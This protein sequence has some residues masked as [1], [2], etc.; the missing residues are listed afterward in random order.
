MSEQVYRVQGPDG[1]IYRL[2]GPRGASESQIIGALQGILAEQQLIAPT[3]TPEVDAPLTTDLEDREVLKQSILE[4]LGAT[5]PQDGNAFTGG[6]KTGIDI[7]QEATG[8][9]LE[10]IGRI[11]GA[12]GLEEYGAEVAERNRLEAQTRAKG[13]GALGYYAQVLGEQVP[14]LAIGAAGLGIAALAAPVAAVGAVPAFLIAAGAAALTQIPLFYGLN[15]QRQKEAIDQGIKTEV[16]ESAAFF[17]SIPQ[18]ALEGIADKLLFGKFITPK[19]LRGGGLFTRAA[20][21]VGVGAVA[22]VPTEIGQQVIERFQAGLDLFSDE[23]ISE[24][25]EAGRAA[26]LV[27]GTVRG[28]TNVLQGD[29][30]IEDKDVDDLKIRNP[31]RKK[32]LEKLETEGDPS[33]GLTAIQD[34]IDTGKT[35]EELTFEAE[36]A[37]INKIFF[38]EEGD[39]D[40]T[41]EGTSGVGVSDDPKSAVVK[42]TA[43]GPVSAEGTGTSGTAGVAADQSDVRRVD[44]RK[45]GD[46]SALA[47]EEISPIPYSELSREEKIEFLITPLGQQNAKLIEIAERRAKTTEPGPTV[48]EDTTPEPIITPTSDAGNV[49]PNVETKFDP[50]E[51]ATLVDRRAKAD[52]DPSKLGNVITISGGTKERDITSPRITKEQFTTIGYQ[53]SKPEIGDLQETV[54]TKYKNSFPNIKI[55]GDDAS[56]DAAHMDGGVAIDYTQTKDKS[57][58]AYLMA[59]EL[60]HASHS[61][62]GNKVNKNSNIKTELK[63]IENFI[64]PN[65][66]EQIKTTEAQNKKIDTEFF[67]YLLSPEELVAE[68]NVYRINNEAQAS[69]IAPN[70]S[71]LLASVEADKNLVKPRNVF[72][73]SFGFKKEV[74]GSFDLEGNPQIDEERIRNLE[75]RAKPFRIGLDK[76]YGS[77][78]KA[79]KKDNP[80][81][82]LDIYNTFI[83]GNPILDKDDLKKEVAELEKKLVAPEVKEPVVTSVYPKP[84]KSLLKETKVVPA[85]VKGKK[86]VITKGEPVALAKKVKEVDVRTRT[87]EQVKTTEDTNKTAKKIIS[88]VE[89]V[90]VGAIDARIK[91]RKTKQKADSIIARAEQFANAP[92]TTPRIKTLKEYT[93]KYG[94]DMEGLGT[95]VQNSRLIQKR[96]DRLDKDIETQTKEVAENKELTNEDRTRMRVLKVNRNELK[97]QLEF[98]RKEAETQEADPLSAQDIDKVTQFIGKK[99]PERVPSKDPK[100]KSDV[101]YDK[102]VQEFFSRTPSVLERLLAAAQDIALSPP[103]INTTKNGVSLYEDLELEIYRGTG[104]NLGKQVQEWVNKNL[105]KEVQTWFESAVKSYSAGDRKTSTYMERREAKEKEAADLAEQIATEYDDA[106]IEAARKQGRRLFGQ[107]LDLLIDE[108]TG[109]DTPLHSMVSRALSSGNLKNTLLAI[110]ATNKNKR[111]ARI[112]ETLSTVVGTTKFEIVENLSTAGSFDPKTNTIKLNANYGLNTHTILHE[113][114]H[115]AVSAEL[116]NKSSQT[117]KALIKQYNYIKKNIDSEYGTTSLDEFIS[118]IFSNPDFQAR[119]AQVIDQKES[120]VTTALDRIKHI[121]DNLLRVIGRTAQISNR[122]TIPWAEY[123]TDRLINSLLAPA[124]KFRDAGE[125]YMAAPKKAKQEFDDATPELVE[126]TPEESSKTL[127]NLMTQRVPRTVKSSW[128]GLWSLNMLTD[129]RMVRKYIPMANKLNVIARKQTGEYD[130]LT[131]SIDLTVKELTRWGRG[132]TKAMA[133]IIRM[134]IRATTNQ[135]DPSKPR[136]AYISTSTNK[137]KDS[138][139]KLKVW[140]DMKDT[141]DSLSTQIIV[142]S[143]LGNVTYSGQDVYNI[144]KNVNI[145]SFNRVKDLFLDRVKTEV[146]PNGEE[147]QK[148]VSRLY[149][150]LIEES[151]IIDPYFS[152]QRKGSY[153]L[154]YN[155]KDP[156][157]D[158]KNERFVHL[159]ESA[160]ERAKAAKLLEANGFKPEN[161][162]RDN[163]SEKYREAPPGSF[164]NE[165]LSVLQKE[166]VNEDIQ[167][168]LVQLFLD[169]LPEQSVLQ[170]FRS[171][172]GVRGFIND[173]TPLSELQGVKDASVVEAGIAGFRDKAKSMARQ[174]TQIKYAAEVQKVTNEIDKHVKATVPKS[175]DK[176]RISENI[177]ILRDELAQRAKFMKDPYVENW[178]KVATSVGF[179]F[180]LGGNVSGAVVNLSQVPLIV[181]PQLAP[182]YGGVGRVTAAVGRASR[183]FTRSAGSRRTVAIMGPDGKYKDKN[184]EGGFSIDNLDYSA[185]E[186]KDVAHLG[187]AVQHWRKMGVLNRTI[188]GDVLDYESP[189]DVKYIPIEFINK[190]SGFFLHHTERYNRQTTLMTVLELDLAKKLK[191]DP[192]KLGEAFAKNKISNKMIRDSAETSIELTELTNGSNLAT[193]APRYAQ[194]GIGKVAFLFKRF[195][196]SMMYILGKNLDDSLRGQS[197][198]VRSAARKK[199]AGIYGSAAILAGAQGVPL[200]GT[201]ATFMNT[202]FRDDDEDDFETSVRKYL[203]EG[204]YGGLPNAMFGIDVST[205]IGLSNLLFRKNLYQNNSPLIYQA[206][207]AVGGP[208]VGVADSFVRGAV[209]FGSGLSGGDGDMRRGVESM[210]PAAIRNGL[211][212]YRWS[213]FSEG[214]ALTRRGDKIV[215]DISP[216]GLLAQLLGFAPANYSRQLQENA[217][218]KKIDRAIVSEHN[219]IYK[220]IYAAIRMQKQ[221]ELPKIFKELRKFNKKYP[222]FAIEIKDIKK[223]IRTNMKTSMGAHHGTILN[224]ATKRRLQISGE[225]WGPPPSVISST[226]DTVFKPYEEN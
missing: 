214:T 134:Q 31:K 172:E 40:G 154:S 68:F 170:A 53:G 175:S 199:L 90:Q 26:A 41:K 91:T 118:E 65:L 56:W 87:S 159:F 167:D 113:M 19:M 151:G 192:A 152:F 64:Y 216:G 128:L 112:A 103:T 5:Q 120:V 119:V 10:G 217:Q 207:M 115:A 47:P 148:R 160:A 93:R 213:D 73:G 106:A 23:A 7:V 161:F 195:G 223:S 191:I 86:R 127:D 171:R 114:T 71:K 123:K 226:L 57:R 85:V 178:A 51:D 32:A 37:A 61:L 222:E 176:A 177:Y 59:H 52:P 203:K 24:Y 72:T 189:P 201:L 88:A 193:T 138:K 202:F 92:E 204:M 35:P 182:D 67:N 165:V 166:N 131:N 2:K 126:V 224:E 66:R 187:V 102:K 186:N 164:V 36:E 15:R 173:T 89:G 221:N 50:K 157:S 140:D 17:W 33:E 60:G 42:K 135:V 174:Y 156:L 22:E 143:K 78:F 149:K 84:L 121:I 168:K 101:N 211:K 104:S 96:I 29:A 150:K 74:D 141:W 44:D 20:K 122:P 110:G 181:V 98:E 77:E 100:K 81:K 218:L 155:G 48:K 206:I 6:V 3:T 21:G 219:G 212:T 132:N 14:Q 205:R 197:K 185:E 139:E 58:V 183:V 28:A 9:T 158:N 147:I 75:G 39:V 130:V 4:E 225:D 125:L 107:K 43:T 95:P 137:V 63:A 38:P 163:I 184:V 30:T 97:K 1:Q 55:F 70:L 94:D 124:P 46:D 194:R 136:A 25:V 180:T 69:T 80:K 45:V 54:K 13:E 188:S 145:E 153:W 105:S 190:L 169:A 162:E 111:V 99:L 129:T 198:E 142:R 62:L 12:E 108:V 117:T 196:M 8:S 34:A 200:F 16:N 209:D 210:L 109:I 146:G 83:K 144:M 79:A 82:A 208:V 76:K 27:G 49:K 116:K 18:A 179:A 220:K 215:E 133:K 11:T